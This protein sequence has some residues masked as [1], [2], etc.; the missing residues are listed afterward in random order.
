MLKQIYGHFVNVLS[1]VS[2]AVAICVCYGSLTGLVYFDNSADGTYLDSFCVNPSCNNSSGCNWTGLL[3]TSWYQHGDCVK[4]SPAGSGGTCVQ[5][6][7][8]CRVDTYYNSSPCVTPYAQT[9]HSET[10]C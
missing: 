5:Y 9:S 6:E 8:L 10:G 4:A 2:L 7:K 1:A 3:W